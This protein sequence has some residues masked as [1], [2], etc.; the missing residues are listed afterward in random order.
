MVVLCLFCNMLY[1]TSTQ[2][3]LFKNNYFII[4]RDDLGYF[5]EHTPH[6]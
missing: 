4:F 5:N 6:K 2:L 1:I 3:M